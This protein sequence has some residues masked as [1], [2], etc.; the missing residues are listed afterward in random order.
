MSVDYNK[1]SATGLIFT[2]NLLVG[3]PKARTYRDEEIKGFFSFMVSRLK[4]RRE[5][6]R[7]FLS[8]FHATIRPIVGLH[9]RADCLKDVI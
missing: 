3:A 5:I 7:T 4:A 8:A 9:D 2:L 6:Q 1:E